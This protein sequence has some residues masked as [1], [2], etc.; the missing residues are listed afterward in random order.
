LWKPNK[1]SI[2]IKGENSIFE[3]AK[4]I[5]AK[6]EEEE[7][8][9]FNK[10]IPLE[11]LEAS[12][13]GFWRLLWEIKASR[14]DFMVSWGFAYVFK[15][16]FNYTNI[17]SIIAETTGLI[18]IKPVDFFKGTLKKR[19]DLRKE[20]Y[21]VLLKEDS[22]I[23][24]VSLSIFKTLYFFNENFLTLAYFWYSK[25]NFKEGIWTKNKKGRVFFFF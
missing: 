21:S 10:A 23:N 15:G 13:I 9:I 22:L 3:D 16:N 12:S 24:K 17:F 6:A 5:I 14:E 25:R 1:E 11:A 20:V 19:K 8:N 2:F 7:V 18:T 4:L